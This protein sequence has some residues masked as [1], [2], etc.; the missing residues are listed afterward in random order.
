MMIRIVIIPV[1]SVSNLLVIIPRIYGA[2]L[3][4]FG[5]LEYPL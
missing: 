2:S 4:F 1:C 5:R 3:L